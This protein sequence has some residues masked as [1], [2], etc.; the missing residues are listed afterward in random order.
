MDFFN[1]NVRISIEISL[2]F[3]SKGAYWRHSRQCRVSFLT[4][5]TEYG[6]NIGKGAHV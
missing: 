1:E 2:K 5:I 6:H 4:V 3:A